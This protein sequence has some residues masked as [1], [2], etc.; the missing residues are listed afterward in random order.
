MKITKII[1]ISFVFFCLTSMIEPGAAETAADDISASSLALNPSARDETRLVGSDRIIE[2]STE[3]DLRKI[4]S[5]LSGHYRLTQNITINGDW[6]PLGNA[7][8]PFT[9]TFDGNGYTI[10]NLV[11]TENNFAEIDATSIG[12]IGLFG[13]AEGAVIKDL[14]LEK[15]SLNIRNSN[16]K[17]NNLGFLAGTFSGKIQNCSVS[18]KMRITGSEDIKYV[19]LMT[20]Y[21][22]ETSDLTNCSAVGN[23][24][25]QSFRKIGNTEHIGI[26]T[27]YYNSSGNVE[28]CSAVGNINIK[29][30]HDAEK[31]GLIAGYYNSSGNVENCSAAGDIT[32]E[33]SDGNNAESVGLIAGRFLISGEMNDCRSAGKIKITTGYNTYDIG[34][35][36]GY[37]SGNMNRCYSTSEIIISSNRDASYVGG[38]A[39]GLSGNIS[40]CYSTGSM[41]VTA[42]NLAEGVGGIAGGL[43]GNANNCYSTGRI[44]VTSETDLEGVGG[45]AGGFNGKVDNCYA[46]NEKV[47][48]TA[49]DPI[50]VGQVIGLYITDNQKSDSEKTEDETILN[51]Y[52][53]DGTEKNSTNDKN[54]KD[55]KP[56][57]SA[58]IWNKTEWIAVGEENVWKLNDN[59]SYRLPIFV[60]QET[61]NEDAGYLDPDKKSDGSGFISSVIEKMKDFRDDIRKLFRF[62]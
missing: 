32:L 45:I 23:I 40:D 6:K 14:T 22:Q 49:A 9:G 24:T 46:L 53:W 15:S 33:L 29:S 41:T 43:N 19:G 1:L 26:L 38:L 50:W 44:I 42:E 18:G 48:V 11:L 28:N 36:I 37:F 13:I 20:G 21:T 55:G 57:S 10:S 3:N 12:N 51:I 47:S 2:I 7:N 54:S 39:G 5:D 62:M 58:D 25:V 16:K 4:S 30:A 31:I 17:I 56:V 59:D 61:L 34:G 35:L 8:E 60:W 52:S 27:G